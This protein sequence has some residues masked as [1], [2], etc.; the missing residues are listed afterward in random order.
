MDMEII[1]KLL[2]TGNTLL[3]MLVLYAC[4]GITCKK[5]IPTGWHRYIPYIGTSMV[6]YF[7]TW[8]IPMDTTKIILE[9]IIWCLL[10]KAV[11]RDKWRNFIV[12]F[13]LSFYIIATV[14]F[15]GLTILF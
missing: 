3:E 8:V 15:L 5:N 11:T 7:I 2:D 4:A 13:C 14:S 1:I 10:M 12:A 6:I 9:M